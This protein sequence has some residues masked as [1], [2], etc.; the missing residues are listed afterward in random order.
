[1]QTKALLLFMVL[2]TAVQAL[3]GQSLTGTVKDETGEPLAGVTILLVGTTTGALTDVD[4]QFSIAAS[5]GDQLR[6]TYIGMLEQTITL[7]AGQKE[8]NVTLRSSSTA[9]DEVIVVGYGTTKKE[10]LTGA[11]D[12]APAEVLESRPLSNLS[13][14]LQGVI[15][16]LNVTFTDGTP[17]SAPDFNIRGVTSINGGSPLILI[18]GIPSDASLVTLL[19]PADVESVTVLK[20]AASAAIYGARGAFGVI[21][22]KTKAGRTGKPTVNY[23]AFGAINTPTILPQAVTDTYTS[24]LLYHEAL[25]AWNGTGAYTE[26]QLEYARAVSENPDM[27]RVRVTNDGRYEYYGNTDWY[28]EIYEE[29]QPMTQHNL[30]F[31]GGTDNFSYYLSGGYL[32]QDGI[33]EYDA[34][35]F[36]RFNLRSKLDFQVTDWLKVRNNTFFN[37][38]VYDYR[39]FYGGTVTM[40]RYAVLLGRA[41]TMPFNPDGTW[42]YP[43][44]LSVAFLRDGGPGSNNEKFLQNTTGLEA[45]FLDNRWK[46]FGDYTYQTD[47]REIDEFF[48]PVTYYRNEL[49]PGVPATRG[50]SRVR[51]IRTNNE[52][53]VFNLYTSF[54][55]EFGRSTAKATVGFNQELRT[56]NSTTS[57][58]D[59]LVSDLGSIN[60]AVGE[61]VVDGSAGEWAVR[62]VFYR[63]NYSFA[64]KYLLEF[65]G[66]YDGTSRFPKADRFGFFPSVSAGWGMSE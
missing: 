24:M 28:D 37:N 10:N 19:N 16:N 41:E 42:T 60:L 57:Q 32:F 40:E 9:L 22:I 48:R 2:L 59:D 20:D 11:V 38:G 17:G 33:Y 21:L 50:V 13:R 5:E 66:R 49:N 1:M 18:D 7:G 6:F 54:E 56:F 23:N 43:A 39:T 8:L 30:S 3:S 63:L 46:V 53:H 47:G 14:G 45:S 15:P 51:N 26:E 34:D 55:Q 64:D 61:A 31:S 52:Y 62:G 44:G 27:E 36:N 25:K 58:R 29:Y 12:Q 65:N 4:G 35:E